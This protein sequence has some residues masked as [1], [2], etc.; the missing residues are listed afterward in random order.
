MIPKVIHY[1]W[2]GNNPKN[3]EVL[4]CIESWKK[5]CPDFEIKEWNEINFPF[6]T[7]PFAFRMYSEKRWAFV[8]DYARLAI[9]NEHGGFYLD[10]DMLL[11]QS[12]E[13]CVDSS[14]V[15]GEEAPSVLNAAFFGSVAH[16]PFV[17]KCLDHYDTNPSTVETIP[18]VMT[19]IYNSL[20]A[21]VTNTI[22]VYKSNVFYPFTIET[23]KEY[24]GQDLGPEVI[25]V[26]L[27]HYSWGHPLNKF[28][29]KIGIYGFGKKIVEFLGIKPILKKLLGFI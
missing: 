22:T 12:L 6:E 21:D 9:L 19:R 23:I 14:C 28:F 3:E 4:S 10:T 11:L 25:G 16:H 8:S 29:K 24:K 26:H 18:I 27:W 5:T 2:F 20:P 15:V 7:S 17:K 13:K 1:C